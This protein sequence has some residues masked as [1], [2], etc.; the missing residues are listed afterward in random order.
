VAAPESTW[1]TCCA[2][3]CADFYQGG[4]TDIAVLGM[5]EVQPRIRSSCCWP[6]SVLM[7]GEQVCNNQLPPTLLTN[8]YTYTSL[9][10]VL[11]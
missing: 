2:L 6:V 9:M 4:G 10:H 1:L 11:Q 3:A 7:S 5:A 8:M